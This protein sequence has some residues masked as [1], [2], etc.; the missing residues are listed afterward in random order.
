MGVGE[1]VRSEELSTFLS[2]LTALGL[3]VHAAYPLCCGGCVWYCLSQRLE[4]LDGCS[5][6]ANKLEGY[7]GTLL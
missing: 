3:T 5:K 1:G 2:P 7:T 4:F 6:P